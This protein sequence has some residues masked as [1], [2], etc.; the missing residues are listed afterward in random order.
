MPS[1]VRSAIEPGLGV[2]LGGVRVHDGAQAHE[3]TSLLQARAAT[4]G[5]HLFLGRG[6]SRYDVPLMAHEATHVVQQGASG[7]ARGGAAAAGNG[8][9]QRLPSAI[10]DELA[11]YARYVPGYTLLTVIAGFD[12]LTGEAVERNAMNLV[13][14]LMG[15]SP[16]GTVV[17]DKLVELGLIDQ[18]FAFVDR[19]LAAFDLS[20]A[21]LGAADLRGLGRDGLPPARPLRLQPRRPRPP[22][23]PRWS[24][25]S[26]PSPVRSCRPWWT[27]SGR[28]R[29]ASPS[30]CWT[31]TRPGRSSRRCCTT[32]RCAACPSRR[33]PSRSSRTSCG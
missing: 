27:W 24:T 16:L 6:E 2:D 12:P 22:S 9:V 32:T 5:S 23:S 20:I 33:P 13:G 7:P 28:P 31:R 15:L 11:D 10:T 30:R 1:S 21:R 26:P 17:F 25:T 8:Q 19:Q 4:Y 29:S 14:G 3:A 18:A